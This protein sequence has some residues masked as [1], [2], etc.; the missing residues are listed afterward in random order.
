MII[1]DSDVLID[2]LHGKE[3]SASRIAHEIRQGTLATTSITS[4]ELL[5]GAGFSR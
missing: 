1:A 3:P 5:S 4:F 2:A